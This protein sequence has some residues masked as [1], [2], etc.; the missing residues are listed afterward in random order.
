MKTYSLITKNLSN[1]QYTIGKD[2]TGKL[3]KT[4]EFGGKIPKYEWSK[5]IDNIQPITQTQN[6]SSIT[7]GNKKLSTEELK[8]AAEY[9]K[10]Y[11]QQHLE[12]EY[13]NRQ[14]KLKKRKVR[15]LKFL[16]YSGYAK[17]KQMQAKEKKNRKKINWRTTLRQYVRLA[18]ENVEELKRRMNFHKRY[19]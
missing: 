15:R 2:K 13:N 7:T 14:N 19:Q 10:K 6:N 5:G 3:L 8:K 16:S 9:T 1:E 17:V 12:E 18:F 4:M 11:N